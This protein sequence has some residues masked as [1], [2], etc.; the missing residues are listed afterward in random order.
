MYRLNHWIFY[1]VVALALLGLGNYLLTNPSEL[2]K[3]LLIVSLIAALFIFVITR[4]RGTGTPNRKEH[5]AFM[6]AVKTSKKRMKMRG[7]SK[8]NHTSKASS[9][10]AYTT[11]KRSASHL[12]VIEGKKGKKKDKASL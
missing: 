4:L 10:K 7:P 11:K 3:S 8:N 5:H 12:T 9:K 1:V 2:F 6:K